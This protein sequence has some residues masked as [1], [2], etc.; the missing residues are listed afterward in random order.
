MYAIESNK[1]YLFKLYLKQKLIVN[2]KNDI[3]KKLIA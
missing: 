3:K 2:L 1:K